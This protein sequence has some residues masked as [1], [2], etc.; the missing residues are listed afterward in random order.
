MANSRSEA[1]LPLLYSI[2]LV[3]GGAMCLRAHT[4]S[5]DASTLK[6]PRPLEK[7]SERPDKA[8]SIDVRLTPDEGDCRKYQSFSHQRQ[9]KTKLSAT[10][11]LEVSTSSFLLAELLLS[12]PF[13]HRTTSPIADV[14]ALPAPSSPM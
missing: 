3:A 9:T 2:T 10:R 14:S 1:S 8:A 7:N 11:M 4:R 13:S 12:L 5:Q 6:L